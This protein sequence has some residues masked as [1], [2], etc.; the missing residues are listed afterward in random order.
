M[1]RPL[2]QKS[3]RIV[4]GLW[5]N[6]ET[7]GPINFSPRCSQMGPLTEFH[8]LAKC[9]NMCTKGHTTHLASYCVIQDFFARVPDVKLTPARICAKGQSPSGQTSEEA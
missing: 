5:V 6:L 9:L 4:N 1:R 8:L 7:I 2:H 3:R